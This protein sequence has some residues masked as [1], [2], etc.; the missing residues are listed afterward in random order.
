M[1]IGWR[2]RGSAVRGQRRELLLGR[3]VRTRS[4]TLDARPCPQEAGNSTDRTLSQGKG[5]RQGFT[6]V[7]R[8]VPETRSRSIALSLIQVLTSLV[9]QRALFPNFVGRGN[10]PSFTQA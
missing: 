3:R 2:F 8:T 6:D 7:M 1:I 9:T 4:S 5:P 10:C